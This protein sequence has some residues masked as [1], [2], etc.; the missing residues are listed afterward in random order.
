MAIVLTNGE[1]FVS[2]KKTGGVIKVKDISQAQ[3]FHTMERALNQ[4]KKAPG[5]CKSYYPVDTSVTEIVVASETEKITSVGN[6]KKIKRKQ[7]SENQR[8]IIYQKANGRC[9]L[10]GRKIEYEDMTLD[11]I[12]PLSLGGADE[13]D[14]LQCTDF[15]CNKFKSNIFPAEFVDRITEIFMFQMEKKHSNRLK[16]KIARNLL[17][18]ML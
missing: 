4:I 14:N 13:M 15:A 11:H 18:E 3:D 16:W 12:V 5:K 7:Y 2:R 17:M 8:K 10:C 6:K 1:L 9:Q